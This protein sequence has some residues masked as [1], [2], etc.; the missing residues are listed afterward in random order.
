[1]VSEREGEGGEVFHIGFTDG[2]DVAVSGDPVGLFSG[3]LDVVLG[4]TVV[5]DL[6]FDPVREGVAFESGERFFDA[7]E[8]DAGIAC[9]FEVSPLEAEVEVGVLLFGFDDADGESTAGGD[10][11][12]PGAGVDIAV[13]VFEVIFG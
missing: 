9:G 7:P 11:V 5:E 2:E 12:L 3:L 10:S 13:D 8:E 4:V 1:M 6:D